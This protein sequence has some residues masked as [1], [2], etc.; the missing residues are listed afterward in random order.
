MKPLNLGAGLLSIS[1]DHLVSMSGNNEISD[2]TGSFERIIKIRPL[3]L[4]SFALTL[5]TLNWQGLTWTTDF[6]IF[7]PVSCQHS[8][9]SDV[10]GFHNRGK[11]IIT[12]LLTQTMTIRNSSL[13]RLMYF[14][15]EF[16]FLKTLLIINRVTDGSW[17]RTTVVFGSE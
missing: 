16:L 12:F 3:R 1:R 15:V 4:Q 6:C 5:T 17:S 8:T 11:Y 2:K 14:D 13:I 9:C 7:L 10:S